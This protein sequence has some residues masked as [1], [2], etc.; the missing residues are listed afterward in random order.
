MYS[1]EQQSVPLGALVW[2]L[3][4]SVGC[5]VF[6]F[7]MLNPCNKSFPMVLYHDF[8]PSSKS[9][10]PLTWTIITVILMV[11][12][13]YFVYLINVI[14]CL[15]CYLHM[16]CYYLNLF[17]NSVLSTYLDVIFIVDFRWTCWCLTLERS[18]VDQWGYINMTSWWTDLNER[19][20]TQP[21]T[22]GILIRSVCTSLCNLKATWFGL[23]CERYVFLSRST[24][25]DHVNLNVWFVTW[26]YIMMRDISAT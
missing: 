13:L 21:T 19:E 24:F 2:S 22:T 11:V 12:H 23:F 26:V 25:S 17:V 20:S 16:D 4:Y 3:F 9:N 15:I 5:R 18:W 7:G 8:W 14:M 6:L 10:Q 1:G